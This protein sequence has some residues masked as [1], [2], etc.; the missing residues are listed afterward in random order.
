MQHIVNISDRCTA[1]LT[2]TGEVTQV[3]FAD[4]F[5]P[6][7][8]TYLPMLSSMTATAQSFAIRVVILPRLSPTDVLLVVNL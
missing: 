4:V 7:V 2:I 1:K 5:P 8:R 3:I 6:R